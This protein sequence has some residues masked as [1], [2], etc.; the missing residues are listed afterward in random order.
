MATKT[1]YF[2][3][4]SPVAGHM[5]ISEQQGIPQGGYGQLSLF[6]STVNDTVGRYA[7]WGGGNFTNVVF[8]AASLTNP[9]L[10]SVDRIRGKF[11]AGDW[12]VA[13]AHAMPGLTT[14]DVQFHLVCRFWAINALTTAGIT[15]GRLLSATVFA[16]TIAT[17]SPDSDGVTVVTA[18]LPQINLNNEYIL[19]ETAFRLDQLLSISPTATVPI[20]G[21]TSTYIITT[22]FTNNPLNACDQPGMHSAERY[23]Y[24]TPAGT[25]YPLDVPRSRVVISSE[26]EGLPPINYL[27]QRG[28]FQDGV[29]LIDEFLQPRIVQLIVRHNYRSRNAYTAG[30]QALVG[31][32]DPHL[33]LIEGG[34]TPGTLRKYLLSGEQRDL[35]CMPLQG[36]NFNPRGAEWQEWSYQEAL[37]FQGFDPIYTN[38]VQHSQ[39]FAGQ[40]SQ[41]VGPMTGPIIGTTL[42][43]IVTIDYL[44][45]WKSYP[46]FT[47]LGPA[48]A[49]QLEN[50]TTGEQIFVNYPLQ[51]GQTI[52]FSLV[53]GNKAV[54]LNDGTNLMGYV[55]TDSDLAEWHLTENNS[56]VN[57]LHA[58]A[59]GV[60]GSSLVTIYWYDKFLG[61]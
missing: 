60:N 14:R 61:I 1:F 38:P 40:G 10:I 46:V 51:S 41:L 2:S 17:V 32:L 30:R 12:T 48:L 53:Q 18:T 58:R 34:R 45:T 24:I 50:L 36:P 54:T 37:R 33:Q 26:G 49:V 42:D 59:V 13:I 25:E 19:I 55:S 52:T 9:T 15:A 29:N 22:E 47:V 16:G 27:T 20:R 57:V 43:S 23:S 3:N 8:P 21:D 35:T 6:P 39:A 28:P 31:I 4:T 7:Y 56:G 11:D 5:G 44:G